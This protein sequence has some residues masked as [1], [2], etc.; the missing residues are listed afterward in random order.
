MLPLRLSE[1]GGG[2]LSVLAIGAHPDDIEIGLVLGR[3]LVILGDHLNDRSR[4]AE[5]ES[6]YSRAVEVLEQLRGAKPGS[7][8]V[9]R[10]LGE[11]LHGLGSIHLN[12]GRACGAPDHHM[13]SQP[14]RASLRSLWKSPGL[15]TFA[16][17]LFLFQLANASLLP[18]VVETLVYEGERRSSLIVSALTKF[19]T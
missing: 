4:T 11:A 5:A 1:P 6:A 15:R 7:T 3:T 9:L 8:A 2:P 18:L 10:G 14:T 17:C 16:A 12:F 13:S 19:R